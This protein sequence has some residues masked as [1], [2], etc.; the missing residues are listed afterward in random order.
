M[1][2]PGSTPLPYRIACLC[3]L[4]DASGRVLLLHRVKPPNK[5]LYSP[6]GGKLDMASGESPAQCARREILEEAGIHIPIDRLHLGGLIS[7]A[8]Y[9]GEGHWLLFYYR[10]L[11]PVEVATGVMREGHLEWHEPDTID[12]LSLPETDRRVIWP[13]IRRTQPDRPGGRPGFFTVHIDCT[14]TNMQW[15]VEHVEPA[16]RCDPGE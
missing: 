14:G 7:E 12:T 2:A 13:L 4:R 8:G 3:D 10:V 9:E 6:I 16:F 5:D 11:G 15:A 1:N